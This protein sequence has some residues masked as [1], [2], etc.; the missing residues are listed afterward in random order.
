MGKKLSVLEW[1]FVGT[2]IAI[3]GGIVL[4]APLSVGFSMLFPDATFVIKSWKEIL[5][6]LA[7]L[8]SVVILTTNKQW[9][10][11]KS[12]LIY[13]IALFAA[14]NLLT[15][16]LFY[17]GFEAT[18]AG[19]FIN[20]RFFL[21]FVLV[22]VALRLYPQ[23]YRLF[24]TV[25]F[26]GAAVVVGFA[27]LQ[28]TVLPNDVLKYL[29]YNESTIMPYLTVDQNENYVRINSTLRGPNPL[30]VY[31]VVVLTVVL[32]A[33]LRAPRKL[34]RREEVLAGILAAGAAVALWASY[35]RSA[36]LAAVA[37]IGLTVLVLYVRRISK[38]VWIAV[39]IAALVVTG[40]LF[41]LRDTQFVSQVILHEDPHEGNDVNSNDG[42]AASL[43][44][45][46]QRMAQQPLGAGIGSTGSASLLTDKPVIIENQYLFVAHETGWLGLAVFIFINYLVLERLWRRRAQWLALGVFTSGIGLAIAGLFLPVWADDTISIIWWGLAAVALAIPVVKPDVLNGAAK[47][48]TTKASKA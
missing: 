7:L 44:D 39:A 6:G 33:W 4:H 9:G 38:A 31:A 16:P 36:A 48:R 1:L 22:Y 12:K 20:L 25:F 17:T 29:G 47:K 41:A 8:L 43:V 13:I 27:I 5:M 3:F 26:I 10:V 45:G 21:F 32:A 35:S 28:V 18:V 42:H 19:V 15:I 37:A 11:L 40:S 30:G 23:L 46:A 14:L 2:L 34:T 24:L